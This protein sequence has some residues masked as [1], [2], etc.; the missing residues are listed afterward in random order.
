MRVTTSSASGSS[1]GVIHGPMGLKVSV[2]LARHSVRSPRCHVRS[3][4]SLPM[5]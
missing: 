2:F 4:T 1:P 3:L 5:V